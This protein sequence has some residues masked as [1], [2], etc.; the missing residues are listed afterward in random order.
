MS[1]CG[2]NLQ[3][4]RNTVRLLGEAWVQLVMIAAFIEWQSSCRLARPVS[5]EDFLCTSEVV[6]G[7]DPPLLPGRIDPLAA[8][9][10]HEVEAGDDRVLVE[11]ERLEPFRCNR[12]ATESF[13]VPLSEFGGRHKL[14]GRPRHRS[15][16]RHIMEC[17]NPSEIVESGPYAA[18]F[19]VDDCL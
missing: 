6:R 18:E 19:P 16:G 9:V 12:P 5:R 7:A 17:G 15:P 1:G 11:R 3:Y 14:C 2:G 4:A 10:Q 13:D 8:P